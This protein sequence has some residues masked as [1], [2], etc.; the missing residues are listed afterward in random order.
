MA[1]SIRVLNLI[2]ALALQYNYST[3]VGI[4]KLKKTSFLLTGAE[5]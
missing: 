4:T 1:V 5:S 3:S 2:G